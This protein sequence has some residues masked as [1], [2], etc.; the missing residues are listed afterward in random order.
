M[1]P[2]D[3]NLPGAVRDLV[4]QRIN[5]FLVADNGSDGAQDGHAVQE[6]IL[7]LYSIINACVDSADEGAR[8]MELILTGMEWDTDE[9][10]LAHIQKYINRLFADRQHDAYVYMDKVLD[11]RT[12]DAA[13]AAKR[14]VA[15]TGSLGGSAKNKA[16]TDAVDRALVHYRANST[17]FASKKAAAAYYEQHFPPVKFSTYYRILRNSARYR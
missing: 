4:E 2:D 9:P 14:G 12:A 13:A 7:D 6:F 8:H 1:W 16:T 15:E 5:E 17:L 11:Q 3:A 10:R